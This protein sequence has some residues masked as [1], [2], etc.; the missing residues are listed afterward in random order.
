[1]EGLDEIREAL[2]KEL[3]A[4]PASFMTV[5]IPIQLSLIA[6]AALLGWAVATYLRRRLDILPHI[7]GWPTV[8]RRAIRV[9]IANLGVI[10]CI[11]ILLL[12]RIGMQ[13]AT[14]PSRSYLIGVAAS[15][16]TA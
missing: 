8:L 6:L 13:H 2:Q 1:M 16:A 14:L 10:I 5:W 9:A 4:I 15:L 11:V 12:M 7:M 3:H